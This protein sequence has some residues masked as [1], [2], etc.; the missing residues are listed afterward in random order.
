MTF[1]RRVG[2]DD[3]VDAEEFEG[4]ACVIHSP[5][6]LQLCEKGDMVVHDAAGYHV[7]ARAAFAKH[8][9]GPVTAKEATT[10][11]R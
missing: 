7:Y 11:D 6:G 3:V 8:F 10:L 4:S 1:Y 9:S 5:E 2:T